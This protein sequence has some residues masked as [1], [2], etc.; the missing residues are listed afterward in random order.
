[1]NNSKIVGNLGLLE[2]AAL[3]VGGGAVA[4]FV[5]HGDVKQIAQAMAGTAIVGLVVEAVAFKF[6]PQQ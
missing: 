1:M 3:A 5:F 4:Y 2:I 6:A